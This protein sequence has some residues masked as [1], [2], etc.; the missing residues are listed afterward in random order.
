LSF[1]RVGRIEVKVVFWDGCC[2]GGGDVGLRGGE[3]V[4]GRG[5]GRGWTGRKGFGE[6][7]GCSGLEI[8]EADSGEEEGE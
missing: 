6:D 7:E 2:E 3:R 8:D 4:R 1:S 5:R